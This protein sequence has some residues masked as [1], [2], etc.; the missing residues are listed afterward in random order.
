[1]GSFYKVDRIDGKNFGCIASKDIEKGTL[2]LKEK[3]QCSA[4][5][6]VHGPTTFYGKK[7]SVW[8]SYINMSQ[9][10]KVGYNKLY[11]RFE[12]FDV[13]KNHEKEMIMDWKVTLHQRKIEEHLIDI[14]IK[15]FGIYITNNFIQGV[16][17][18]ASRFNHSCVSNA[19]EIW[20]EKDCA[21]EIRAVTDIKIGNEITIN[22][23]YPTISMKNFKTRQNY[24]LSAWNFQCNCEL[25][26]Y[27]QLY[28]DEKYE[29]F[30]RI[31][32]EVEKLSRDKTFNLGR[33]KMEVFYYCE[34]HR[35]AADAKSSHLFILQTIIEP[36]FI[37]AYHGYVKISK[38]N[39]MYETKLFKMY[40][41]TFSTVGL[42]LSKLLF[43]SG[44]IHKKWRKRKTY[45]DRLIE[46]ENSLPL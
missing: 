41:E 44:T 40:C 31:K 3:P 9:I 18:Q 19:E 6:Y 25:C 29:K 34:M 1:M 45:F 13:L 7:K 35:L 8:T 28:G 42:N 17:I 5:E 27:D 15:V 12:N 23:A 16:G 37:A 39:K 33:V 32:G 21:R 11:N 43:G 14:M 30:A 24:L 26:N 22:Y 2:I 20:N 36:G 38:S 46:D 4:G 10:D